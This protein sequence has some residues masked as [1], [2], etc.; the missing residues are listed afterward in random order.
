MS[1][2]N[3]FVANLLGVHSR[4]VK[5]KIESGEIPITSNRKIRLQDAVRAFV[6]ASPGKGELSVKDQLELV[7]LKQAQLNYNLAASKVVDVEVVKPTLD[8]LVEEL[9]PLLRT[10]H[11]TM[12]QLFPDVDPRVWLALENH[13]N[14]VAKNISDISVNLNMED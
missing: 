7:K 8:S 5:A 6:G 1:A 14:K 3:I 4:Q 2:F 11:Q 9:A 13:V 10:I 12:M